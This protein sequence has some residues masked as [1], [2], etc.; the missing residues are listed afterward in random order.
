MAMLDL[1]FVP[2]TLPSQICCFLSFTSW[3][4]EGLL[5]QPAHPA[6]SI[7]FFVTMGWG[8]QSKFCGLDVSFLAIQ[9]SQMVEKLKSTGRILSRREPIKMTKKNWGCLGLLFHPK[10]NVFLYSSLNIEVMEKTILLW[11]WIILAH[12]ESGGFWWSEVLLRRNL[13]VDCGNASLSQNW[14]D[15]QLLPFGLQH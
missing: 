11:E 7:V 5:S 10:I 1:F 15:S 6:L 2:V 4:P 13:A 12:Q 3:A 8:E 14:N 9:D